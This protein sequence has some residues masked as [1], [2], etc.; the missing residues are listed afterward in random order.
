MGKPSKG[1]RVGRVST[2]TYRQLWD[3]VET[4]G[5]PNGT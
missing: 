4:R 2:E 3:H 1:E 5:G